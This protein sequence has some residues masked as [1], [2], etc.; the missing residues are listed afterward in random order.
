MKYTLL[1][2]A[3]IMSVSLCAQAAQL[4]RWTDSDGKVH[5]T[6]EPPPKTAKNVEHKTLSGNVIESAKMSYE[7]QVA[8]KN[9][10]VILYVN[11]CG[12]LC[13][14]ARNLLGK[15]GVPYSEKN[16]ETVDSD[17]DA[18][19]KLT[20]S[21]EIPVLVVGKSHFKGY[22]VASWNNALDSAGYPKTGMTARPTEKNA[23]TTAQKSDGKTPDTN[24]SSE[25]PKEPAASDP[26]VTA[27]KK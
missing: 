11:N 13:D 4:Y 10:P 17:R 23:K 20:G 21:L 2:G 6:D 12:A 24:S 3:L 8:V 18:L 5:Y 15:R 16:P 9:S 1:F 25:K 26:D 27:T 7:M 19:K 14:N 22:D